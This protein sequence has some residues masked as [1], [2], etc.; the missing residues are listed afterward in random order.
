MHKQIIPVVALLTIF[1]G[2]SGKREGAVS[3]DVAPVATELPIPKE[4]PVNAPRNLPVKSFATGNLAIGKKVYESTCSLCHRIGQRGA[5]RLGDKDGW[6]LRLAQGNEVL[7][8]HAINGYMGN[9]GSM[10]SRGSNSK[11]SENEVRAAVDYM[12]WYSVPKPHGPISSYMF[13]AA[14]KQSTIR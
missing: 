3:P 5:P 6:A 8:D 13:P 4:P 10:P 1:S 7:Y 9:K 2:C 11:L 14:V 12:V